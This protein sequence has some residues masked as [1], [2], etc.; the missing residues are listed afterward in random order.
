MKRFSSSILWFNSLRF[1]LDIKEL[2]FLVPHFCCT[3]CPW[4]ITVQAV[5]LTTWWMPHFHRI[6]FLLLSCYS[7]IWQSFKSMYCLLPLS[8][9]FRSTVIYT[10]IGKVH[11]HGSR[12]V[13]WMDILTNFRKRLRLWGDCNSV[14]VKYSA[15]QGTYRVQPLTFLSIWEVCTPEFNEAETMNISYRKEILKHKDSSLANHCRLLNKLLT[16]WNFWKRIRKTSTIFSFFH[17]GGAGTKS[18]SF[19]HVAS[20]LLHSRHLRNICWGKGMNN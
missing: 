17:A 18:I 9:D 8:M 20:W 16:I 13:V 1:L 12:R 6:I 7:K 5:F 15:A 19:E 3:F 14:F 11:L 10:K 2:H 4:G